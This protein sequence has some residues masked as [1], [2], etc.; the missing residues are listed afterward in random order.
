MAD[1]LHASQ[2]R[3]IKRREA[4]WLWQSELPTWAVIVTVYAGWFGVVANWQAFFTGW[5]GTVLQ[6]ATT[7]SP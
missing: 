7:C 1:Y 5:N 3:A 2:R 6:P 4:H